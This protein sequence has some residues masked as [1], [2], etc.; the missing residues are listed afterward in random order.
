M[1]KRGHSKYPVFIA[2][3]W[4]AGRRTEISLIPETF[5]VVLIGIHHSN[6]DDI[7]QTLTKK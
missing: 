2:G 1:K 7:L 4:K 3:N 5:V 6:E